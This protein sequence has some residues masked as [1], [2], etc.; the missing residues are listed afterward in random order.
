LAGDGGARFVPAVACGALS[1]LRSLARP[2][3]AHPGGPSP[4]ARCRFLSTL[5]RRQP[6]LEMKII[7]NFNKNE[8]QTDHLVQKL[9]SSSLL[10]RVKKLTTYGS[11][12]QAIA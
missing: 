11:G 8:D 1:R 5:F 2:A 7:C 4:A 6:T 9:S 3:C 10:Q 12:P